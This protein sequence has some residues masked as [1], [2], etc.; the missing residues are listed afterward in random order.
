MCYSAVAAQVVDVAAV[1]RDV[2]VVADLIAVVADSMSLLL[3]DSCSKLLL[4]S[5]SPTRGTCLVDADLVVP[6]MATLLNHPS[7]AR[8]R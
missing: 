6:V 4:V 8:C 1:M 3:L 7:V 2:A 5:D